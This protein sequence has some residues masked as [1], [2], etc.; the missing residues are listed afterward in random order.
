MCLILGMDTLKR[1]VPDIVS[2]HGGGVETH[3]AGELAHQ[4]VLKV[5]SAF[6]LLATVDEHLV[7]KT[8]V[9]V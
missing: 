4:L 1:R 6:I 8:H 3:S 7:L 2:W 5:L 9:L